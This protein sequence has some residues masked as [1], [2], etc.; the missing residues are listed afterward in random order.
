MTTHEQHAQL[1]Y[2]GAWHFVNEDINEEAGVRVVRGFGPNLAPKPCVIEWTFEDPTDRYRPTNPESPLYGLIGRATPAAAM[3]DADLRAVGEAASWRP[4][5]SEDFRAS[6]RRGWRRVEFR[7]EGPLRRIGTWTTP[8]RSPM[9]RRLARRPA[10]IGYWPMEDAREAVQA[11]NLAPNGAP[12]RTAGLRF[13]DQDGPLGSSEVATIVTNGLDSAM[14]GRFLPH[15]ATAGWQ[16][17]WSMKLAAPAAPP[18][19]QIMSWVTTVGHTW[20]LNTDG[21]NLSLKVVDRAGAVLEDSGI[22]TGVGTDF[23]S[24]TTYRVKA[25]QSGGNVEIEFAWFT[26]SASNTYGTAWSYAGS[27]GALS[28]WRTNGNGLTV[29]GSIAHV[30]GVSDINDD[31]FGGDTLNAFEGYIGERAAARFVRLCAEEGLVSELFGTTGSTLRMG[32]QRADTFLDLLKEI[33]ATDAALIFDKKTTVGLAM[34]TRRNLYLQTPAMELVWPD[35]IAPPFNEEIDDADVAN[36]VVVTQRDGGE[37][38]AALESGP[39]SIQPIPD[40]IGEY[41]RD[42][43]VNLYTPNEDLPLLAGWHLAQGTLPGARYSQIT[44]DLDARPDLTGAVHGVDLGDTITLTGRTP[45]PIGLMVIGIADTVRRNRRLVT[46]TCAPDGVISG[47]GVYDGARYGSA[48]TTLNAARDA[49]QTSWSFRTEDRRD[50]WETA[51]VPY[52][53]SCGGELVRVTA[54][55][56]PT[57]SGPYLQAATVVRSV[58]GVSKAQLAGEPIQIAPTGRYAL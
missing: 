8:L 24:W 14:S 32:R 1:K 10:L 27:V 3:V 31:L 46:F 33:A 41:K 6:P 20:Y 52:E 58:N 9:A 50:C 21:I 7:A 16:I 30:Y 45:D 29:D 25:Y 48:S 26:Q 22:S 35:D 5:E 18:V 2:G 34:R 53:V 49:T 36:L 57:G 54:M 51:A 28:E 39:M 42:V 15:S 37:A 13:A 55:A 19:R 11:S 43:D 38:T 44:I 23:E 40:G 4:L 47:L 56:A 17:A 12:A